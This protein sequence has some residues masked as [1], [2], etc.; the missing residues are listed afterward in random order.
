M[1]KQFLFQVKVRLEVSIELLQTAAHYI[2]IPTTE[3]VVCNCEVCK[4]SASSEK[5]L[6]PFACRNFYL[7]EL[8]KMA[9][10]VAETFFQVANDLLE[11]NSQDKRLRKQVYR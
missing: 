2:N 7:E 4:G 5:G 3:D 6:Q 1:G 11:E 10:M 8:L 9:V